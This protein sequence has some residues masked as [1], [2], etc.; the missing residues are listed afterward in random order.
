[1]VIHITFLD[2]LFCEIKIPEKQVENHPILVQ[3]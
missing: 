2:Y 1:M 3:S